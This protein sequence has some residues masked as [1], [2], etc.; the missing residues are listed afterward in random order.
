MKH[1]H[2][3]GNLPRY[4]IGTNKGRLD[5]KKAAQKLNLSDSQFH[6]AY[7]NWV[8]LFRKPS[9]TLTFEQYI[10]KMREVGITPDDLGNDLESYNLARFNDEGPYTNESCRFIK[11]RENHKEQ[12]KVTP[13]QHIVNKFGYDEAIARNRINAFKGWKT[14]REKGIPRKNRTKEHNKQLSISMKKSWENRKNN[15]SVSGKRGT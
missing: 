14:F 4:K 9:S 7:N 2:L 11:C 6:K 10:A 13:F 15:M 3:V 5:R 8:Q 12:K 1:T